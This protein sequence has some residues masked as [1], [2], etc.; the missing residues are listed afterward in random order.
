MSHIVT[1]I[2]QSGGLVRLIE[3]TAKGRKAW[4]ALELSP[5]AYSGYCQAIRQGDL[6]L[7]DYGKVLESGWGEL[8]ENI[9]QKYHSD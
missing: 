3:A 8:P 5:K 2:E 7:G 9:R 4:Y 1:L 6:N